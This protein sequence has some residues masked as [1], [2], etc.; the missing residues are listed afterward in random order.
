[1]RQRWKGPIILKGVL[2][3]DD[4][5]AAVDSGAEAIVVSNHGGRQLDGAPSSIALLPA[6]VDAVGDR[7]K[8]SR[9]RRA[10]GAG[11]AKA[12][13]LG[14]KGTFIGRPMLYGLGAGGEAGVTRV[15]EII[16]NELD[17]TLAL[18][19]HRLIGDAGPGAA[20]AQA[21]P[22]RWRPEPPRRARRRGYPS[23]AHGT[24]RG[25]RRPGPPGAGALAAARRRAA[26][27]RG[28]AGSGAGAAARL[29]GWL[30][31]ERGALVLVL[32]LLS[33]AGLILGTAAAARLLQRRSPADA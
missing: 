11:S 27:R 28:L 23:R 13:A 14:A 3:V 6:I 21:R 5:R 20:A 31:A 25:L 30:P 24:V 10:L 9:W 19:G 4:A 15:L 32:Y 29:P 2:D 16:R 7:P 33:F 8:C 1:M 17:I 22:A 12:I 26:G 18:C